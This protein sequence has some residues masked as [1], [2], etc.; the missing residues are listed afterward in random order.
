VTL[1]TLLAAGAGAAAA[2]GLGE[3]ALA[4]RWAPRRRGSL[5]ALVARVGASVG[6]K[7]PQGLA[8]RVAAAGLDRPVADVVALQAGLALLAGLAA[9]PLVP[10]LPGRLGLALLLGAPAT[11]FLAP[12]LGLRRRAQARKR[13]MEIELPDVLDLLRVAVGAGLAP[14]RALAEVGRRH[15]GL[16]ARELV[17]AAERARLGEPVGRALDRLA[18][19]SPADGVP[20][21][22]AALRRAERHGAPL[23]P[24]LAAQAAEARSRRAAHRSELAARAAP[25][26]QL[27]VA[28]LLVPAVLLLVA[29]AL[30]P[31][32]A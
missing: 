12:E 19:R 27:V 28:L 16:L 5:S 4:A 29:A 21:L 14:R 24:T 22:V 18:A 7:A 1:A 30:V 6:I 2:W 25:K 15:P 11:G 13:A 26:I 9:L 3:L 10:A 17:R 31:A 32:V 8:A 20:A 23:A